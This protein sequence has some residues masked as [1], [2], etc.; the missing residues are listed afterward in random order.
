MTKS[1]SP[2]GY[3]REQ[4]S[5]SI[6]AIRFSHRRRF[7]LARKLVE[8]YA[9][10]KLLDYGCGDA[11]FLAQISDIFPTAIGTDN[12]Q[13]QIE[14]CRR[15][16]AD[17]R[18]LSFC[19]TR[20]LSAQIHDR[21]FDVITCMEVLEHCVEDDLNVILNEMS[22][23]ISPAGRIVISVPIE[24]GPPLIIKQ[25]IRRY[26]SWRG[27]GDYQYTEQYS[28]VELMKMLFA[29]ANTSIQRRRHVDSDKGI[30][31]HTHMGFNWRHLRRQLARS[32]EIERL[33]F[34]PIGFAGTLANSQV[35]FVCR[36]P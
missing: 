21:A 16:L 30:S 2:G 3:E 12:G 13:R 23:L 36:L 11:T 24:I 19:T 9:G 1:I 10:G 31:Y 34:S 8:K 22:R 17:L 26:A 27:V 32:F 14:D 5:S 35:W 25:V 7:A 29:R 28:A 18:D 15:R 20:E 4:L 33:V 6:L